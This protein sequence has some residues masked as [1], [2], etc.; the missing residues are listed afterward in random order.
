MVN[1]SPFLVKRDKIKMKSKSILNEKKILIKIKNLSENILKKTKFLPKTNFAYSYLISELIIVNL[2]IENIIF[3]KKKNP[4]PETLKILDNLN[5]KIDLIK[6]NNIHSNLKKV[7]RQSFIKEKSHE[8]L[9]QNLWTNYT[10]DQYLK[11]RIN[12]YRKRIKINNLKKIIKNK[13]IVDFGCGHGNFLIAAILEGCSYGYGID[14]G[15]KSIDYANKIKNKL[16][17]KNKL[18]FKIANI[19][20]TKLK[21][22]SFD[23]AIQNG[24]FHHLDNPTKAYKELFRVLKKGGFAWFYTDGGGGIRDIIGDM[25]Q[26]ILKDI[27]INFKIEKIKSLNLSFGK[28]YHMSDNTNAKYQHYDLKT[29]IKYLKKL[30]FTNFK[31]LNGGTSTDFDKP[32]LNDRY[33]NLKFGSGDL[34]ILCQKK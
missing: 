8:E 23:I 1:T 17:L 15:K 5:Y 34:R 28:T 4:V 13:S 18:T 3:N 19:Y 2:E 24:V 31:Q 14:Y 11:D 6:K 26:K 22:N 32:F 20:N 30:G 21:S 10:F 29:Y 12:R 7:K 33:F 25:S 16:K 9:F 27:N